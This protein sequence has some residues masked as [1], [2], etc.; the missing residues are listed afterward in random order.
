VAGVRAL[1]LVLLLLSLA[2]AGCGGDDSGDDGDGGSGSGASAE[3]AS[4][5]ADGFDITF[6]YPEDM[7]LREEVTVNESAGAEATETVAL[8]FDEDDAIVVQRFDLNIEI[9]DENLAMAKTELDGVIAQIDPEA[10]SGEPV[11]VGGFPGFEYDLAL[12]QPEGAR[13]RYTVIF[14]GDVEYI[15]NCQATDERREDM[16]AACET[17]LGSVESREG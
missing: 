10:G 5:D 15:I 3:T 9:T 17:A 14:D 1:S 11:D 8:A 2:F 13:S 6:D 7:D 16:A 12:E 4:F